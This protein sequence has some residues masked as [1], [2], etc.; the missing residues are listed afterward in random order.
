MRADW[1]THKWCPLARDWCDPEKCIHW[2]PIGIM[3][4]RHG[5]EDLEVETG[6]CRLWNDTMIGRRTVASVHK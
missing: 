2:K 4:Y 3:S 1:A 5:Y 6:I